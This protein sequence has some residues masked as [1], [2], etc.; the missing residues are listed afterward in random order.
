MK[1]TRPDLVSL[2]NKIFSTKI[3]NM[4]HRSPIHSTKKQS[5]NSRYNIPLMAYELDDIISCLGNC[6]QPEKGRKIN[7]EFRAYALKL[8]NDIKDRHEKAKCEEMKERLGKNTRWDE[9]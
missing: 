6:E 7:V 9:K 8:L 4:M 3:F 1:L 5:E 2:T